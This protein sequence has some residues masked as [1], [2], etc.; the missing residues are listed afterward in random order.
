MKYS[1]WKFQLLV[2]LCFMFVALT[3]LLVKDTLGLIIFMLI[4][5]LFFVIGY[6]EA[7]TKTKK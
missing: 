5:S 6:A 2:G 3:R 7:K 1:T 4:A